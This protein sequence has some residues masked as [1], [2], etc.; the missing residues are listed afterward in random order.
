MQDSIDSRIARMNSV[1]IQGE[2]SSKELVARLSA[3]QRS[4]RNIPI[5]C[6][7]FPIHCWSE[8]FGHKQDLY[9][10]TDRTGMIETANGDIAA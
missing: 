8:L 4:V 3:S 9:G 7:V 2:R 6:G 5:D 1:L 10:S